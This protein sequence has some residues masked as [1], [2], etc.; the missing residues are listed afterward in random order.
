MST[1][2]N[3]FTNLDSNENS[4]SINTCQPWTLSINQTLSTFSTNKESGLSETE[5][6]NRIQ[7]YGENLLDDDSGVSFVS[8]VIR[9]V[10]NAMI[11]VLLICMAISFGIKDYIAG[12]V[13]AG[14][15]FIN[16]GVGVLQELR[17]EKTMASLRSLSSP[18]AHVIRS[19]KDMTLPSKLLVP[20]DLVLLRVG[21]TIPADSRILTSL[22][23]ET[24]EA[25]LTGESVPVAKEHESVFEANTPVGDRINMAFSSSMVTKG[26]ATAIVVA[27]GMNTEIGKTAASLKG[28]NKTKF[29]A[30]RGD[31]NEMNKKQKV[32]AFGGIIYDMIGAFLGTNRGTPLQR[33]LSQLSIFLFLVAVVLAIIAMAAQKFKLNREVAVYAIALAISMIPASLVVVLTITMSVGAKSMVRRHVIVRKL[34]SL[35]ALGAVNDICSDKTGTITQGKML[36]RNA[37]IPQ[38]GEVQV[39]K[40][41]EPF[42]PH[43]GEA[44]MTTEDEKTPLDKDV[45]VND[46]KFLQFVRCGSLANV[47]TVREDYV[48]DDAVN[49]QWIAHGDPTEIA[50]QVFVYRFGFP[51]QKLTDEA[52]PEFKLQ[53]EFPFDSTV[54]RMSSVYKQRGDENG[55]F[56]VYTKGAVERIL[57]VCTTW[58][59]DNGTEVNL[60]QSGKDIISQK[61]ESFAAQGLRVLALAFRPLDCDT[62][63]VI[64]EKIDRND[65]ESNLN[66]IGLIGIYD[67]PREESSRSVLKCRRAGINVHMLTGDHPSTAQAIA[68]EVGILPKN[69]Y[70]YSPDVV[71]AMVMTAPEFDALTDN[72]IDQL[73][74]LPLVIAR[75]APQTKVRMIEA[76]HRRK[77]FTAMTGDGVNDSPSL[78]IADVGIAM[79]ITGSDVAKDAS[80]IVLSDDNFASIYNAIEEGRRMTDNIRKFALHLL[81]G[82]IS[83]V[84]FLVVGLAFKDVDDYSVFPLSPVE[85][86]WIIMIT[87]SFPAMG[88]GVEDAEPDIMEREPT[89]PKSVIFTWEV[90]ID[91]L[92]YGVIIATVCL[93]T[94]VIV[95]YAYGNGD[96][97][98]DCNERYSYACRYVYRGRSTSFVEM[99]WCLLILAWEVTDLKRSIFRNLVAGSFSPTAW[100]QFGK[101]LYKN[102]ML[103]W[104][105][106]L[107]FVCVFPIIYIPVINKKVFKHS[108][109]SWEWA[110]AFAGLL[111]F[112]I[113]TELYKWAKRVYFRRHTFVTQTNLPFQ[114]NEASEWS[115]S[116]F[117]RYSTMASSV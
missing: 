50:I 107:G 84:L 19:E 58:N 85:V 69:L 94:F 101:D 79:G 8:I 111:V 39:S 62:N 12:G 104:S 65:V 77:A 98:Y 81:A 49:K 9:Q 47:A 106:V 86:L 36:A 91:M 116:S 105:I 37:W 52:D 16:V 72:Q 57:D 43:S 6:E 114:D 31:L 82:N 4:S 100:K 5:A 24:D 63:P 29:M 54:K 75:C 22:N 96:L 26:R 13:I 88:L 38:L 97:A 33:L 115:K 113:G 83:Q 61:A 25:L 42:N 10:F 51:R 44:V 56:C 74:V 67:P 73:P 55:H 21:D 92:V 64:W 66:F 76:L 2:H 34:D 20:G 41:N 112:L 90:I 78:K 3:D 89:D 59:G 80:D 102:K 40:V 93:V 35:E 70:E 23:F 14:V 99:T 103:F 95:V 48:G 15:F 30:R 109:I 11:L 60:T 1:N 108:P 28:A 117:S 110:L 45:F 68:K 17:A 87:S 71:K 18:T 32:T 7:E 27:T 53:T 46:S